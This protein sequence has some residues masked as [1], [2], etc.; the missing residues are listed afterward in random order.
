[1]SF[2]EISLIPSWKMEKKT[3]WHPKGLQA[4]QNVWAQESP[5]NLHEGCIEKSKLMLK[6]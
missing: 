1:M 5:R 4:I 3:F 2:M 6:D